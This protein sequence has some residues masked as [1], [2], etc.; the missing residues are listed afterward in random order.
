MNMNELRFSIGC[1]DCLKTDAV[2]SMLYIMDEEEFH[3]E[4]TREYKTEYEAMEILETPYYFNTGFV[5][6]N[7]CGKR[8]CEYCGSSNIEFYNISIG[9]HKFYDFNNIVRDCS[10]DGSYFLQI[11]I[12][13]KGDNISI[14]KGGSPSV[15]YFFLEQ[16][17]DIIKEIVE[18]QSIK[19]YAPKLT[20]KFFIAL[21]G[22][23]GDIKVQS[24]TYSGLSKKEILD[25]LLHIL[26]AVEKEV[27]DNFENFGIKD[28]DLEKMLASP[29]AKKILDEIDSFEALLSQ[30]E[31]E[32]SYVEDEIDEIDEF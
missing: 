20:G 18:K 27:A 10:L 21:T 13:K 7:S 30:M 32:N 15:P 3:D 11:N 6:L 25:A 29:S 26:R 8:Q 14:Q 9:H 1:R 31:S 24:L 17:I 16:S 12:S 28:D 5:K 23:A 2:P 4:E 22:L 19:N